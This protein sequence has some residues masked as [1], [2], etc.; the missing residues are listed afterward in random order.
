MSIQHSYKRQISWDYVW[1]IGDF[2]IPTIDGIQIKL[3]DQV[4]C[5]NVILDKRMNWIS[6]LDHRIQK[7]TI[8]L[9]QCRKANGKSWGLSPKVIHWIYTSVVRPTLLYA[10]FLWNHICSRK[11]IQEKLNKFQ[12]MACKAITGAWQSAP[13]AGLE[14]MLNLTPL[15][16]LIECEAIKVMHRLSR[17]EKYV[18]RETGHTALWNKIA[19]PIP[20]L[21]F[22]TD[23]IMQIF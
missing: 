2:N 6:N 12:R 1:V 9:W 3:V 4:K 7:A 22:R 16:I 11:D 13:T 18:I 19:P 5:L 20:A 8:C 14:A 15:H 17:G 10:S 21:H 23:R